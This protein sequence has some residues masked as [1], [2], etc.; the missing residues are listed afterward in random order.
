MAPT[1]NTRRGFVRTAATALFAGIAL[2][3]GCSAPA[4]R[5]AA[6]AAAPDCL[7]PPGMRQRVRGYGKPCASAASSFASCP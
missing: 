2:V 7:S 3:A 1:F 5:A 4:E 6:P